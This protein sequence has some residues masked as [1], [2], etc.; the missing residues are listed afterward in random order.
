M[1]YMSKNIDS[2]GLGPNLVVLNGEDG[3]VPMEPTTI[4]NRQ[5]VTIF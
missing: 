4:V 5:Y 3:Q 1:I 2:K